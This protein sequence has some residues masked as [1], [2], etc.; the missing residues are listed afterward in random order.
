MSSVDSLVG[1]I[2]VRS[3]APESLG[4]SL[5]THMGHQNVGLKQIVISPLKMGLLGISKES[6]L[7]ICNHGE[8]GANPPAA[9]DEKHFYRGEEDVGKAIVNR[10][11]GRN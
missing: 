9:R 2:L 10:V 5:Y 8:P 6:P 7:G 11:R 4:S 3:P 1:T